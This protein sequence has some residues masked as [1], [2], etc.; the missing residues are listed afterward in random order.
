MTSISAV[1]THGRWHCQMQR[2]HFTSSN[3][4]IPVQ[5]G[6]TVTQLVI[7]FSVYILIYIIFVFSC[8]LS[9]LVV[10]PTQST[11]LYMFCVVS[12][13]WATQQFMKHYDKLLKLKD[14]WPQGLRYFFS[15]SLHKTIVNVFMFLQDLQCK[16]CQ[17]NAHLITKMP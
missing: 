14:F 1:S 4:H 13:L 16:W 9:V 10:L 2:C 11:N 5:M 6:S 3:R 7:F 12:S 8:P 17:S 15:P